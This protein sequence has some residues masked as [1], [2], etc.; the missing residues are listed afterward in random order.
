MQIISIN[1]ADKIIK[2]KPWPI[3]STF[4]HCSGP[5][6]QGHKIC[7]TPEACQT[8]VAEPDEW[9]ATTWRDSLAFWGFVGAGTAA[10]VLILAL[11][12][13]WRP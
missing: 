6:D 7:M 9:V 1:Q 3:Y 12:L 4:P 5:C 10:F 11:A 2:R 13:G 8:G